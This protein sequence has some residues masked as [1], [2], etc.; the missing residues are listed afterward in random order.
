MEHVDC[1]GTTVGEAKNACGCGIQRHE[2][3]CC[4][5]DAAEVNGPPAINEHPRIIIPNKYE[6]GRRG[7]GVCECIVLLGREMV[8]VRQENLGR[9]SGVPS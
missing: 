8:V 5:M 3:T 6:F 7:S 2:A 9:T 1:I 4:P